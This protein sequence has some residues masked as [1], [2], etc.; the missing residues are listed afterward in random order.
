MEYLDPCPDPLEDPNNGTSQEPH[1][2]P[3]FS[4][5]V[6]LRAPFSGYVRGL[7]PYTLNPR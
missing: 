6:I 3:Q 7:K 5:G 1:L 2:F 4:S